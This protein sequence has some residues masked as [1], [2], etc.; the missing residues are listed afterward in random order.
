MD[1][2]DSEFEEI[3]SGMEDS[4]DLRQW[5]STKE[6]NMRGLLPGEALVRKWLPPG[7]VTDLFEHYRSTQQLMGCQSVS[8]LA[9]KANCHL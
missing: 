2:P 1:D 6:V 9:L 3:G 5:L 4:D 7:T 8:Q